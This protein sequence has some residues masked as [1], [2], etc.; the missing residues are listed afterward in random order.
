MTKGK[1]MKKKKIWRRNKG[2]REREEKLSSG[3]RVAAAH[4]VVKCGFEVV[5]L[6]VR[7]EGDCDCVR[8]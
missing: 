8:V 3:V 4:P 5:L 1:E 7:F 6:K 2:E